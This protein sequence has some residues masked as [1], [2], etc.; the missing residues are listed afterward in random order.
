MSENHISRRRF[1]S[2][3]GYSAL[4]FGATSMFSVSPLAAA[5][6]R[7]PAWLFGPCDLSRELQSLRSLLAQ[8]DHPD[9]R[10]GSM[11]GGT[12]PGKKIDWY[13]NEKG[14]RCEA[15]FGVPAR[16]KDDVL[17]KYAMFEEMYWRSFA[18]HQLR[19]PP[20]KDR[21]NQF[22]GHWYAQLEEDAKKYSID[23]GPWWQDGARSFPVIDGKHVVWV[24]DHWELYN[25]PEQVRALLEKRRGKKFVPGEVFDRPS[26]PP[27]G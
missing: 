23:I 4:S 9:F 27:R 11:I 18:R 2:I 21:H 25:P 5:R 3:F 24:E 12:P 16:C 17:R 7:L 26:S 13:I 19:F 15:L 8:R 6:A 22:Y 20:S 1:L 14:Q 10:I